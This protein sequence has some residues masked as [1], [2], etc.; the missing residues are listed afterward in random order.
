MDEQREK[1]NTFEAVAREWYAAYSPSL[2]PKHSAKLLR[3]P[4][5]ILFP[6]FGGKTVAAL[7]RPFLWMPSGPRMRRAYNHGHKLM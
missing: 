4:E 7:N 5:T 6:D 2:T 3:Y 1:E